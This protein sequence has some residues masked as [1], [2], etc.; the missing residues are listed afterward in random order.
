MEK[1]VRTEKR[2]EQTTRSDKVTEYWNEIKSTIRSKAKKV[3]MKAAKE[4]QAERQDNEVK[5]KLE[6]I[7]N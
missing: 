5:Q 1:A 3:S 7:D 4:R 2:A 6:V